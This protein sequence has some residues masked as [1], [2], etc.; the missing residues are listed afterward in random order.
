[1]NQFKLQDNSIELYVKP[2]SI[3]VRYFFLVLAVIMVGL[4]ISGLIY[5]FLNANK[6][7]FGFLI[8]I[9]V[10]SLFTFYFL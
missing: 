7:H 9:G 10:F 6:F 1:M 5:N 2:S 4:P 3:L 8:G